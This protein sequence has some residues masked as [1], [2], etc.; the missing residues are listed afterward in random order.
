MQIRAERASDISPIEMLTRAAFAGAAHSNHREQLIIAAL[1]RS[2]GLAVSLV[3][4]VEGAIAGHAAASAV[5]ISDGTSGWYGLGPVSVAP[6]QQRRGI[7]S[8]LVRAVL[9]ALQR[10]CAAG[11]VVLG[12]PDYYRRFGF[13]QRADLRLPGVPGEYFQALAFAPV[14]PSGDVTYDA[15]FTV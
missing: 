13:C 4:D 14:W 9:S 7:G 5:A 11:C 15:A 12:E 1:R 2:G 10:S 8:E 6:G 3:A